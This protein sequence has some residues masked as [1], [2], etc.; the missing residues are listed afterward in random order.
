M[1]CCYITFQ[2]SWNY[3][4]ITVD[5]RLPILCN[6]SLEPQQQQWFTTLIVRLAHEITGLSDLAVHH[7][8]TLIVLSL[9]YIIIIGSNSSNISGCGCFDLIE[10]VIWEHVTQPRGALWKLAS[11]S[12]GDSTTTWLC[13][14]DLLGKTGSGRLVDHS[15]VKMHAV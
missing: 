8:L 6:R 2:M 11:S 3:R 1:D 10:T 12:V 4:R 14:L 13:R 15:K 9:R 7:H 5:V